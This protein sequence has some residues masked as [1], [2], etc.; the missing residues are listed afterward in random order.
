MKHLP[1]D[2]FQQFI[3][4]IY[5]NFNDMAKLGVNGFIGLMGQ[6]SQRK[7]VYFESNFDVVLKELLDN[8]NDVKITGMLNNNKINYSEC[9]DMLRYEDAELDNILSDMVNLSLYTNQDTPFLYKV[10]IINEIKLF[11]I[12]LP[13]HRKVYDVANMTIYEYYNKIK[14]L[15][16]RAS[17][18]GIKNGLLII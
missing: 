10:E 18:I 8:E 4:D 17:L 7:K 15:N 12:A 6:K 2:H 11:E 3:K 1:P 9:D 13:I 14:E 5:N 16:T